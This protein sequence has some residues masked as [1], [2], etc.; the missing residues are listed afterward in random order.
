MNV[1]ARSRCALLPVVERT[2]VQQIDLAAPVPG[3]IDSC[4]RDLLR[5]SDIQFNVVGVDRLGHRTLGEWAV[6]DERGNRF[7]AVA[8]LGRSTARWHVP[9]TIKLLW[10]VWRHRHQIPAGTLQAHRAE[11]GVAL[12]LLRRDAPLVQYLHGDA[13]RGLAD[14]SDSVWRRFPAAYHA[15]ETRVCRVARDVVV[16]SASGAE[17]L[18]RR[19]PR[20]RSCSTWFD[21]EIF[22]ADRRQLSPRS[23]VWVGRLESPKDPMLAIRTIEA[24]DRLHPGWTL[25]VVGEGSLRSRLEAFVVANQLEAIVRF[26]GAMSPAEVSHALRSHEVHLSTSHFEGVSRAIL[27]SHACGTPTVCTRDADPSGTVI[28]GVTGLVVDSRAPADLAGALEL[29]RGLDRDAC[30]RAAGPYSAEHLVPQ[31]IGSSGL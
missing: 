1:P 25:L 8:R 18:A 10:G 6:I 12:G 14:T 13:E 30:A 31:A 4:I 22:F 29:A 15:C 17:R 23:A 24:A 20:V 28:D 19:F 26:A 27:E 5:W 21:P 3:G 2:I 7:M 11:V 9:D 16:F